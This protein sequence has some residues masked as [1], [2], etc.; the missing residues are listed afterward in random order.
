LRI[1]RGPFDAM[2]S[3]FRSRGTVHL[4]CGCPGSSK[5]QVAASVRASI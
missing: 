2:S 5:L 1:G 3:R 4:G